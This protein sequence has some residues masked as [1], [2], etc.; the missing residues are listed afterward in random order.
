MQRPPPS[1]AALSPAAVARLERNWER[2]DAAYGYAFR[3]AAGITNRDDAS[4]YDAGEK[5]YDPE[6]PEPRGLGSSPLLAGV[7]TGT[8]PLGRAI[9][10]VN[11][12][13][14]QSGQAPSPRSSRKRR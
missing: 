6:P 9:R 11:Q 10:A 12:R 14:G 13:C 1:S 4:R 3:L 5:P 2:W 8:A 7:G